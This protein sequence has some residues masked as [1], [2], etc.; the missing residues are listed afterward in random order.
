[1]ADKLPA[2]Q[3]YVGDW[4]KDP[5][6]RRATHEE[7]G[8]YID[9]LCL[10]WECEERGVLATAGTAWKDDEIARAVGGD[11]SR[12]LSC[13]RSLVEKGVVSR[14]SS[15]AIYSRRMVKDEQKRKKCV[16]AGHKGGNPA[17]KGQS[18]GQSKGDANRLP[19]PS[20]SVSSSDLT[21]KKKEESPPDSQ[22]FSL[23]ADPPD[24]KKI[25][26]SPV[27]LTFPIDG[28]KQ[29]TGE[30]PLT[31]S[32]LE[33]YQQSFPSLDV[34]AQMRAARQ[35]C[36]DNVK[37]RKTAVGM[38]RFLSNW[39]NNAQNRAPRR[40]SG[41]P[42]PSKKYNPNDHKSQL[43]SLGDRAI[44]ADAGNDCPPDDGEIEGQFESG[45]GQGVPI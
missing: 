3:F 36:V 2:F 1:M 20:S 16:E 23:T 28:E 40:S 45:D 41:G 24:K 43:S 7:K 44:E 12:S 29:G 10:M 37:Q 25:D 6:V 19:T 26:T 31:Q 14:N 42:E 15:G 21:K 5:N 39:L 35:W 38:P 4:W 27:V 9:M 17:L 11:F 13:V 18:K 32:K 22:E 33:E 30:W 8:V 34:L